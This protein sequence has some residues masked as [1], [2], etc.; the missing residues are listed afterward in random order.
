MLL[1]VTPER[2][3]EQQPGAS[4][5]GPVPEH[6]VEVLLEGEPRLLQLCHP[7]RAGH[8]PKLVRRVLMC[9]HQ[10]LETVSSFSS[11]EREPGL[12][13]G[14]GEHLSGLE[15]GP[16]TPGL[17]AQAERPLQL[18]SGR[19]DHLEQRGLRGPSLDDLLERGAQCVE[20]ARRVALERL[21][22]TSQ[23]AKTGRKLG[24]ARLE[25]GNLRSQLVDLRVDAIQCAEIFPGRLKRGEALEDAVR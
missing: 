21:G 10:L 24:E 25:L 3:L 16:Q 23:L 13:L 1:L 9:A 18:C 22:T 8:V 6:L 5:D 17:R 15:L 14:P 2:P 7:A 4:E 19:L 12:L 20:S 11:R